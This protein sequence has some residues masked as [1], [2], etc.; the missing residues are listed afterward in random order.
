MLKERKEAASMDPQQRWM[1]ETMYRAMENGMP[2]IIHYYIN[3]GPVAN[4][5]QPVSQQKRRRGR[6]LQCLPLRWRMI[7]RRSSTK[8]QMKRR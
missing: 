5:R 8:T 2:L 1:L 3:S 4:N 6:T 7:M